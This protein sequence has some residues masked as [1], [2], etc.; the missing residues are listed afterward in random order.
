MEM[1]STL[2][3]FIDA[4]GTKD[5]A[6]AEPMF[7]DM[8]TSKVGDAL[9]AEKIALANSVYNDAEEEQLELDIDEIEV[10]DP[11]EEISSEEQLED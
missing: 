2:T 1:N 3:D 9:D 8:M 11:V 4:V 7:K 5:F 10:E 6:K